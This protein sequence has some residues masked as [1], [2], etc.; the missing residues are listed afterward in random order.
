MIRS[1]HGNDGEDCTHHEQ[2]NNCLH[3][4]HLLFT[5]RCSVI[6]EA[7]LSEGGESLPSAASALACFGRRFA[8]RFRALSRQPN[9]Q[10]SSAL[11]ETQWDQLGDEDGA[12]GRAGRGQ[13]RGKLRPP[14]E[15]ARAV[16]RANLDVLN[17]LRRCFLR[18]SQGARYSDRQTTQPPDHENGPALDG[19]SVS[20]NRCWD[21]SPWRTSR[22][23]TKIARCGRAATVPPLGKAAT[24]GSLVRDWRTRLVDCSWYKSLADLTDF[25]SLSV[26]S[27]L[28]AT[29][30]RPRPFSINQASL[31]F[32]FCLMSN[33]QPFHGARSSNRRSDLESLLV[34][35]K[36]AVERQRKTVA[37]YERR[38]LDAS[39]A[40][41]RLEI[42]QRTVARIE[43]DL[44]QMVRE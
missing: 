14:I 13:R 2:P 15:R 17:R 42:F 29:P 34:E 7:G 19:Q 26:R 38:N 8:S 33:K 44:A 9:G 31:G 5:P 24:C 4:A 10:H 11:V 23:S 18:K 12:F 30:R 32:D 43:N 6:F 28:G 36:R 25:P 27:R 3:G 37:S 39:H 22:Y 41:A 16:Q 1:G 21:C 35:A 20:G 40:K